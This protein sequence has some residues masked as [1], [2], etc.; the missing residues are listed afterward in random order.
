MHIRRTTTTTTTTTIIMTVEEEL[1]AVDV[2]CGGG[3][4]LRGGVAYVSIWAGFWSSC[5]AWEGDT[6]ALNVATVFCEMEITGLGGSGVWL[7]NPMLMIQP[8]DASKRLVLRMLGHVLFWQ[9][10][11]FPAGSVTDRIC[12][13]HGLMHRLSA[14]AV[15]RMS[16]SLRLTGI[17]ML[18]RETNCCCG[19][20]VW[21]LEEVVCGLEE[22]VCVL[23]VVVAGRDVS[24]VTT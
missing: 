1:D 4:V 22:V 3:V 10:V 21:G 24:V 23:T 11:I 2:D 15:V 14:A 20:V 8:Y 16:V 6:G 5:T 9:S 12:A 13:T 17:V 18:S 7:K 19:C